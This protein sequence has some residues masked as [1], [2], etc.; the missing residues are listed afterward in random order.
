MKVM[1]S[2]LFSYFATV[3]FGITLNIPRRALNACGL[4]GMFGWAAYLLVKE[5]SLGSML[6]NLLSAFVIGLGSMYLA[7]KKFVPTILLN[8][9]SLVPLVPGGQAYQA[10]KNFAMHNNMLAINYLVQVAL[11]AGAIAMGLFLAELVG[12]TVIKLKN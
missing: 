8:T 7:R 12:Q 2:I 3:G 11:V 6:A 4:V 10:V 1:A 5:I 9:P